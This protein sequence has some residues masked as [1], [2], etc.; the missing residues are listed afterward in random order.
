M[1]ADALEYSGPMPTLCDR[2]ICH[3]TYSDFGVGF[4]LEVALQNS[5]EVSDLLICMTFS[6][7]TALAA[8]VSREVHFQPSAV[9]GQGDSF[10]ATDDTGRASPPPAMSATL[11][12]A[13]RETTGAIKSRVDFTK[14]CAVL[15]ICPSVQ[16]MAESIA[17][18]TFKQDMD[19]L[20]PLLRP[21]LA[22]ILSS[23][24]TYLR[25]LQP[26][27]KTSLVPTP[28]QFVLTSSSPAKNAAFASLK[29]AEE[30]RKGR[31]NGSVYVWAGS[32]MS[33]WHDMV[34]SLLKTMTR[35]PKDKPGVYMDDEFENAAINAGAS[36]KVAPGLW[37]K[38]RFQAPYFPVALCEVVNHDDLMLPNYTEPQKDWVLTRYLFILDASAMNQGTGYSF[39]VPS[40]TNPQF[41]AELP[42][43]HQRHSPISASPGAALDF[44]P[45][46]KKSKND[47]TDSLDWPPL[48]RMNETVVVSA[49]PPPSGGIRLAA[50]AAAGTGDAKALA[51][52][53]AAKAVDF[54]WMCT[55]VDI[56]SFAIYVFF[57][58]FFLHCCTASCYNCGVLFWSTGRFAHTR[59]VVHSCSARCVTL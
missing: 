4:D 9:Q 58:K 38:S 59:I 10:L 40:T 19:S 11:A 51:P 13:A 44:P 5:P 20:S 6:A 31:G 2:E 56:F 37:R 52:V 54:M 42:R 3:L 27:E 32:R 30:K 21:L 28:H 25:A 8:G 47:Q 14:V 43:V 35:S 22:W 46:S 34:R 12:A 7:M 29:V 26:H 48:S 55:V 33:S 57:C 49:A 24:R 17:R 23:N 1:C 16:E 41:L 50:A 53:G 36:A 39:G 15:N 18:K 45:P